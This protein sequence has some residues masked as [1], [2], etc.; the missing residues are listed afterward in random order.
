MKRKFLLL[1]MMI[2]AAAVF[3][4]EIVGN[5]TANIPNVTMDV[6]F[7]NSN[8]N[9]EV[10][11]KIILNHLTA[12]QSEGLRAI[13]DEVSDELMV[14]LQNI[15]LDEANLQLNWGSATEYFAIKIAFTHKGK[16]YFIINISPEDTYW[17]FE[18]LR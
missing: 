18:N 13:D 12:T 10:I 4:Q 3:A 15:N 14:V 6:D 11:S 8:I 16:E 2:C 17:F 1:V 9:F 5:V 7:Y